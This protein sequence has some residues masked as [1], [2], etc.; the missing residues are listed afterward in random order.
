VSHERLLSIESL[1][2]HLVIGTCRLMSASDTPVAH[3]VNAI[4]AKYDALPR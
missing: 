2:R 4:K 1:P 3:I